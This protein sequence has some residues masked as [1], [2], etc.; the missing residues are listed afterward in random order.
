MFS[1]FFLS[2]FAFT[3]LCGKAV[4]FDGLPSPPSNVA[5]AI[6]QYQGMWLYFAGINEGTLIGTSN[7]SPITKEQ[8]ESAMDEWCGAIDAHHGDE[9]YSKYAIQ[10]SAWH[11]SFC[12]LLSR[13]A[14]PAA[15]LSVADLCGYHYGHY[16]ECKPSKD[17]LSLK[18]ISDKIDLLIRTM[19]DVLTALNQTSST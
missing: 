19:D 11:Q 7:A 12:P 8:V 1:L 18:D 3:F 16:Y 9:S 10:P 5:V 17:T 4:D 14:H 13:I 15:A 6:V 2:S